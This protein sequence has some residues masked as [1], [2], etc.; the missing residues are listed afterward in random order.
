MIAAK[1]IR[2]LSI[3]AWRDGDGW[4]WNNWFSVGKIDAV[5]LDTL[6]T[7]RQIL[8]WFR[9]EGYLAH[10]SGGKCEID[11]DQY[12]IVVCERG[13]HMP[14]YAIEYGACDE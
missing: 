4:Q 13:S 9:A 8:A 7:P 11:D 12:N 3:D 1:Q 5:T 14:L 6:K 2:I 10:D